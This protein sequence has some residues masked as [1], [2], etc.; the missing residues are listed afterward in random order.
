MDKKTLKPKMG[1]PSLGPNARRIPVMVKISA[2]ELAAFRK[3]AKVEGKALGPWLFLAS[4]DEKGT[5]YARR[6]RLGYE[7]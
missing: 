4:I 2:N 1:R 5:V 6:R 3:A 7:D